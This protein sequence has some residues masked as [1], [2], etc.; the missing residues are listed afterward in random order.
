MI[1]I[2]KYKYI[3]F[4]DSNTQIHIQLMKNERNKMN[5]ATQAYI[6]LAR[7]HLRYIL[8]WIFLTESTAQSFK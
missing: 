1:Q 3:K 6:V 7:G 4:Y 8:Y 2:H 5:T